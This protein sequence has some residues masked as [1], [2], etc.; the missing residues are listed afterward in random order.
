MLEILLNEGFNP[1]FNNGFSFISLIESSIEKYS[2][3]KIKNNFR[4]I[5]LFAQSSLVKCDS[6]KKSLKLAVDHKLLE[7]F[8]LL[9]QHEFCKKEIKFDGVPLLHYIFH[10]LIFRLHGEL[11]DEKLISQFLINALKA[12]VN[13]DE[14]DRYNKT[15]SEVMQD[16]IRS[17]GCDVNKKIYKQLKFIL[18]EFNSCV[19][20]MA[21]ERDAQ[22]ENRDEMTIVLCETPF[23]SYQFNQSKLSHELSTS[24][25]SASIATSSSSF[26]Y[27]DDDFPDLS[28]LSLGKKNGNRHKNGM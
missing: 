22:P 12:G 2:Y 25:P 6:L 7:V 15:V 18:D 4:I 24:S 11:I 21:L 23:I 5:E 1:N 16:H 28:T 9:L 20:K 13:P 17:Y 14:M 8:D 27:N 3:H 26:V 19:S 10:K